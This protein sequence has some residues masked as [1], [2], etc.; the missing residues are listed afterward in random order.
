MRYAARKLLALGE[1]QTMI[2]LDRNDLE[3][4]AT[5]LKLMAEVEANMAVQFAGHRGSELTAPSGQ[6]VPVRRT[7]VGTY[8]IEISEG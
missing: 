8:F 3:S 2:R 7:E 5:A 6:V 1:R 4:L